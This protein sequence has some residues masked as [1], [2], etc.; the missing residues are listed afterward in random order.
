M[1]VRP[2]PF[3]RNSLDAGE[4][5]VI[6]LALDER[7][8]TVCIDEPVG[9]RLARLSGLQVTGAVGLLIRPRRDGRF[10]S[11][12]QTLDRMKTRGI[13]LSE[14]VVTFALRETGEG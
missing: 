3:L 8:D 5:A 9:R 12:R 11:M 2:L 7:I 14:T 10:P 6:Q 4:A 13:W 1:P